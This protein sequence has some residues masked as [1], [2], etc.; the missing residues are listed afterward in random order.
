MIELLATLVITVSSMVLFAY[1]FRYTSL[2]ILSAKTT[3]DYA[4]DVAMANSLSFLE[5]QSQ[6]RERSS[7]DPDRLRDLLDRDYA[8]VCKLLEQG[9]LENG[10]LAINYRVMHGWYALSRRFSTSAAYRALEEMSQTVAY[11][12]NT[13]GEQAANAA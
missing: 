13:V 8:I 1:W 5:V 11:F 2:L 12:A 7:A 3:R 6:L 9:S 4:A 10:M